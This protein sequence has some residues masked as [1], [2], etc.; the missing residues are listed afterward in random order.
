MSIKKYHDFIC[1][2]VIYMS[3][4]LINVLKMVDSP[5]SQEFLKI[6]QKDITTST[7]SLNISDRPDYLTYVSDSVFQRKIEQ[8]ENPEK[9]SSSVGTRLQTSGLYRTVKKILDDNGINFNHSDYVSFVE[10]F[11]AAWKINQ[12][13][14]EGKEL[15][16]RTVTGEEIRYWYNEEN[17]C[18]KTLDHGTLGKSCMRFEECQD[19]FGIYEKNPDKVEL[20]I[21]V[22]EEEKLVARALSWKTSEGQYLDRVYFTD[23][24]DEEMLKIW[25]STNRKSNMFFPKMP[26]MKVEVDFCS[27]PY[28]YMDTFVF[29]DPYDKILYNHIPRGRDEV[30]HCLQDTDGMSEPIYEESDD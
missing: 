26:D 5:V 21:M 3:E 14:S 22:D 28:P 23:P 30:L 20:I 6:S 27:G 15:P 29:L 2:S 10:K 16:I 18:E 4:G 12:M 17:Y 13:I 25:F 7:N 11:K 24:S 1:E 19:F 9:I 8:G